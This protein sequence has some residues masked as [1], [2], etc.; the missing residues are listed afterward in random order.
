MLITNILKP[1]QLSAWVKWIFLLHLVQLTLILYPNL[2]RIPSPCRSKAANNAQ[3]LIKTFLRWEYTDMVI[4]FKKITVVSLYRKLTFCTIRTGGAS[5]PQS[6]KKKESVQSERTFWV[7]PVKWEKMKM[8]HCSRSIDS[9]QD[10]NWVKNL[11]INRNALL[12]GHQ[13][14]MRKQLVNAK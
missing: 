5:L 3:I 14:V 4:V 2:L 7:S 8:V 13:V 12:L 11:L 6:G 9:V 1:R 10:R